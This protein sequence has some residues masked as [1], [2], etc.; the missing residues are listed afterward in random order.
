MKAV[1]C[2]ELKHVDS[3]LTSALAR[4]FHPM[5]SLTL[6]FSCSHLQ[7]EIY[8][9]FGL[10]RQMHKQTHT[11]THTHT[12]NT[13]LSTNPCERRV[14]VGSGGDYHWPSHKCVDADGRAMCAPVNTLL[15]AKSVGNLELCRTLLV[16]VC[17]RERWM[18]GVFEGSGDR[19]WSRRHYDSLHRC[20][21][22]R[23]AREMPH[24]TIKD[25]HAGMSAG[26]FILDHCFKSTR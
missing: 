5:F 20:V 12:H 23:E 6:T 22:W 26:D 2:I 8:C 18:K 9:S 4:S 11:H 15:L 7:V 1:I 25:R 13:S 10:W 14:V 16:S 21:M 19:G 3:T 17:V 24:M